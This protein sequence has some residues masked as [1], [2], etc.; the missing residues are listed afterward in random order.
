[1]TIADFA[2]LIPVLLRFDQATFDSLTVPVSGGYHSET[3]KE[4]SVL[5]PDLDANR[6]AIAAFL[7]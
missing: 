3:I 2:A 4:S 5:V 7:Q 1:M 6:D